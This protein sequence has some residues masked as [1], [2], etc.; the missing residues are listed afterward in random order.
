MLHVGNASEKTETCREKLEALAVRLQLSNESEEAGSLLKRYKDYLKEAKDHVRRAH[1]TGHGGLHVV[2]QRSAAIDIMVE[3][4]YHL[5][6]SRIHAQLESKGI[7]FAILALGGYGREELCPFSDIDLMF[8]CPDKVRAEQF[9]EAQRLFNDTILYMLWDLGLKVGHSTRST[10]EAIQEAGAEAQSKNAMMEARYICGHKGLHTTFTKAYD[11]FIRKDNVLAYLEERLSDQSARRKKQGDSVFVQ[12]PDIKNGVGGLRDYQNLLWMIRLQFDRRDLDALVDLKLLRT[13]EITSLVKAYD[14]LLRVRNEL[15][16]QSKRP[17]DL[18]DFE[19][20]P[21]VAWSLGYRQ[22]QIFRRVETFMRDYYRA[23][24]C[25][26]H[27]SSYL[28]TRLSLNARTRISFKSVLHSRRLGK[29]DRFDGFMT[30]GKTL[31]AESAHVFRKDPVRLIRVFR[32][33]QSREL[34]ADFDLER[35]IVENLELIDERLI[36]SEEANRAFRSILQNRGNVYP[37]LNLMNTTGVLPRFL[38]E[39]SGLHCLV[40]HEFYHRYTA[41]VHTLATIHE[42]DLVV[43]GEEPELTRKYWH[44]LEETQLP[45]LL[46]LI[47]LLHDIGKAKGIEDH[48][49]MGAEIAAPLL[50]RLGVV[51]QAR[52]KILF[53]IKNHLEMARIWQKYD[54]DDPKTIQLLCEEVDTPEMLHYL[55]VLTFCDARGTTRSLWNSF[56]DMLHTRLYELAMEHLRAPGNSQPEPEMISQSDILKNAEG[57]SAEEVEAHFNLLP[58]RYFSYHSQNE[59]IMHLQM[60]HRLLENIAS[61]DSI[62]SLEPVIDWENDVNLGLTVVHIVTWDRAGLFFKLAGAF[63]LAGLSIV[64]SKALSRADHITIDTF[65]VSDPKGGPVK[66][67]KA[68][69]LFRH[70]L[71]ETLIHNR[72]L[73]EEIHSEMEKRRRPRYL[74]SSKTLP[75]NI[76]VKVDVYHELSLKRTIIEIQANDDLGLLYEVSRTISDHGYDITFARI[77][78]ERHVAVDTFYIQQTEPLTEPSE[79]SSRLIELKEALVGVLTARQTIEA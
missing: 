3:Q 28:E 18:L 12:E 46:Y 19:K 24:Q 42:L 26:F 48:A 56:K 35:L 47:L 43:A 49:R 6:M 17:S 22:R 11:S 67:A 69:D 70:Y 36:A 59:I 44:A 54:L 77:S 65:Y 4:L 10:R 33:L 39:W 58:E 21:R 60:I 61:A 25:I 53:L 57:L 23:A 9:R 29:I 78:T 31:M 68:F 38:P 30:H 16:F 20:Q 40:Q 75:A 72:N 74:N 79:G 1:Q 63:T 27:L 64:S 41:D 50:D 52:E 45:G 73:M 13:N 14:F 51:E 2:R 76:P 32:H 55:Y 62:G 37:A 8:L 71:E 7:D 15:H 66:D 34:E 5:A